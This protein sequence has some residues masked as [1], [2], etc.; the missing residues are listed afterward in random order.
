MMGGIALA[1]FPIS[2]GFSARWGLYRLV[3]QDN[4][5]QA[6]LLLGGSAGVMMGLVSSTRV[7]LS[8]GGDHRLEFPEFTED[9]VV[10]VLILLLLV[11]IVVLGLFP[12]LV[13]QIA[14]EMAQGFSFFA[15]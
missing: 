13:S 12:Q 11:G 4:P 15:E 2:L 5:F 6:L 9:P 14:L 7:L 8:R 3:S 1:G 10:L